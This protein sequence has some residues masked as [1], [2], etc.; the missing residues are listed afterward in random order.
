MVYEGID[1]C[2]EV[3]LISL[4]ALAAVAFVA[5][6]A[7]AHAAWYNIGS[8]DF[9]RGGDHERQ[10]GNFG[11]PVEKLRFTAWGNDVRCRSVTATFRNGNTREIFDGGIREGATVVVDMPGRQREIRRLDFRCRS[12]GRRVARINVGVDL[13]GYADI[14]RRNPAWTWIFAPGN[15]GPL[16]PGT[17]SPVPYPPNGPGPYPPGGSY[18]PGGGYPPGPGYPGT[19]PPN[20]PAPGQFQGWVRLGIE[21]FEGRRDRETT[22]AGWAGRQ[23]DQIAL[24]AVNGDAQCRRVYVTFR[25][26]NTRELDIG[27]RGFLRQGDFRRIDLPG[28]DRNVTALQLACRPVGDR[29]VFIESYA[30][31]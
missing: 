19:H 9:D 6:A 28:G 12:D 3:T 23:V 27:N 16:P 18:P 21:S 10:Y 8:V 17:G 11:G 24:R 13:G 2:W 30:R 22:T 7:P 5:L 25:N 29:Q 4:G 14:W 26:G 1:I 15:P 31:R 20:Y